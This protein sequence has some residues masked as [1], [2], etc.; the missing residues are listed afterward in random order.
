MDCGVLLIK[1]VPNKL[2]IKQC[3]IFAITYDIYLS[4][5]ELSGGPYWYFRLS[6]PSTLMSPVANLKQICQG[7]LE[8][9]LS[10]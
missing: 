10:S 7:N 4:P 6:S 8:V 1:P 3:I 2:D 9:I 5:S